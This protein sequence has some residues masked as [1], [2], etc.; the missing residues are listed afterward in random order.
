MLSTIVDFVRTRLSDTSHFA[1]S[2]WFVVRYMCSWNI[3]YFMLV[4][5]IYNCTKLV[6][7]LVA[8]NLLNLQRK[9]LATALLL[10]KFIQ[11]LVIF[12]YTLE[13]ATWNSC[14]F[15]VSFCLW[16]VVQCFFL[17]ISLR[18]NCRSRK[19]EVRLPFILWR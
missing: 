16:L 5:V 3:T 19:K 17:I 15:P 12:F 4:D 1:F 14:N 7:K 2:V 11:T 18:K 13:V 8:F 6:I 9:N 10:V